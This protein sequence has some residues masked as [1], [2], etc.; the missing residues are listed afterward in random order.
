MSR[1]LPADGPDASPE[2][3]SSDHT[4]GPQAAPVSPVLTRRVATAGFLGTFIEYYDF[5]VYGF[6]VV[7]MAPLFFP[8]GDGTAAVL[9]SLVVFAV[10]Y[11]ARPLGGLFFGSFGDRFGRRRA[12]LV[13]IIGMGTSTALM[14][15]LP[16]YATAGV[17]AP[18]LLVLTRLLQGFSAGG[19][20]VGS[21]TYLAESSEHRHRGFVQ[22][23]TP[24]GSNLGVAATP[25]VV[26][27]A[28]VVVGQQ[29]MGEWGWRLPLLLSALL[30]VVVVVY[31]ARL[32]DSPEFTA[33]SEKRAVDPHPARSVLREHPRALLTVAMLVLAIT[34]TAGV[35][36]SYMNI[37]MINEVGLPKS[38]VYWLSA[39][40]IA[41]GGLGYLI[42]GRLVDRHGSRAAG[43]FGFAGTAILVYPVMVAMAS[44]S[45]LLLIG[46]LYTAALVCNSMATPAVYVA[47]TSIFPT[48]VRYT[49]A[50]IGFNVGAVI[51]GGL[52]PYLSAR[53]T[54]STGLA[55]APAILVVLAAVI[56]LVTL[57]AVNRSRAV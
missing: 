27:L 15:V 13:T 35:L 26:A 4:T 17:L 50:A 12:L 18:I 7:Y 8:E 10:G 31:R 14:G 33:L 47:F 44:S 38:T 20:I 3:P 37:Y 11:L 6:L 25:A 19:E 51:G 49:G 5:S 42:G 57:V 45:S 52:T 22:A 53:L 1:S 34:T 43:W 40:A 23:L 30:T 2:H 16:T 32:E 21:A 41:I 9:A 36:M 24:M 48:R 39:V 46:L 54:A 28:A 55:Q 29:A 56:G